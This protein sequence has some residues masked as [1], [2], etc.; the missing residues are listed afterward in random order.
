M[1][2]LEKKSQIQQFPGF[3]AIVRA[4]RS[5]ELND[6][7]RQSLILEAYCTTLLIQLTNLSV[8][9]HGREGFYSVSRLDEIQI[10]ANNPPGASV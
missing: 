5:A 1:L 2:T 8:S 6:F 9:I 10:R 7:D 3:I 4:L